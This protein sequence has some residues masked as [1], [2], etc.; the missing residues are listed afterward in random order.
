[1]KTGLFAAILVLAAATCCTAQDQWN[2]SASDPAGD[3]SSAYDITEVS[4]W[5]DGTMFHARLKL[6][7]QYATGPYTVYGVRVRS[8]GALYGLAFV[9]ESS[10]WGPKL[11]VSYD[12]GASW[13]FAG[14]SPTGSISAT[15]INLETPMANLGPRPWTIDFISGVWWYFNNYQIQDSTT[16]VIVPSY[17]NASNVSA[18]QRTDGSRIVDVYYDILPVV[19]RNVSVTVA[20]S[21]NGG[22]SYAITPTSVSGDVG[23][24]VRPGVGKHIAWDAR[25]DLPGAFGANYKIRLTVSY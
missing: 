20:V 18:R 11:G 22:T 19:N 1:M 13:G 17:L 23:S 7:G 3:A 6:A 16:T 14:G 4:A 9:T 24:S 5:H 25:H 2:W 15:E 10:M 21:A 12:N 8:Q